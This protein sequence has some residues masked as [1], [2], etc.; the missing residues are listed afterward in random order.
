MLPW[1]FY[2]CILPIYLGLNCRVINQLRTQSFH[3]ASVWILTPYLWAYRSFLTPHRLSLT[4]FPQHHLLVRWSFLQACS[5]YPS[6]SIDYKCVHIMLDSPIPSV[7]LSARTSAPC[8]HLTFWGSTR[9]FP[10]TLN[11]LEFLPEIPS[12]LVTIFLSWT[13][14]VWMKWDLIAVLMRISLLANDLMAF[15]CLKFWV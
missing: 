10:N 12:T 2:K 13:I 4:Q 5:W 15:W 1:T 11:P 3:L 14:P 9:L 7:C 6:R 8:Y